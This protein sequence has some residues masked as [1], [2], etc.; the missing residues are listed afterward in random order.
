MDLNILVNEE[1][2]EEN[3]NLKVE[4]L[5]DAKFSLEIQCKELKLNNEIL[6]KII[7]ELTEQKKDEK[8]ESATQALSLIQLI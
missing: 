8:G 6:R 2:K 4:Y 7:R 1:A 5:Q 3:Q